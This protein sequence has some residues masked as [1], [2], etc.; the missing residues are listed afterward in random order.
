MDS[1]SLTVFRNAGPAADEVLRR[2]NSLVG[3]DE[4]IA[5]AKH[6]RWKNRNGNE[7]AIVAACRHQIIGHRHLRNVE[8]LVLQHAPEDFRR[9]HRQIGEV[10]TG[11]ADGALTQRLHSVV[12]SGS[13]CE[14]D[15][16]HAWVSFDIRAI[17]LT[18]VNTRS[19]NPA[20]TSWRD[21]RVNSAARA[22]APR[23][24][25]ARGPARPRRSPAA[26]C[27]TR[28]PAAWCIGGCR[29]WPPPRPDRA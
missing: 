10:Y 22:T 1:R 16:R 25:S 11:R 12:G 18:F 17:A 20:R 2:F 27:E 24:P 6:P 7:R 29:A 3:I 5:V 15:V 4:D 19:G 28:L 14:G 21:Y 13:K 8:L 23:S 26:D 9:L